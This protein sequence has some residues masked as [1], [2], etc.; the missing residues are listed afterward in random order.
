[1]FEIEMMGLFN[2]YKKIVKLF[3]LD[4]LSEIMFLKCGSQNIVIYIFGV[5]MEILFRK[6]FLKNE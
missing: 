4:L 5:C 6:Y 2:Q 1:M 3:F